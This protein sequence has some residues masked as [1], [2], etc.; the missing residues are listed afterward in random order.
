[1][2]SDAPL[3]QRCREQA[4]ADAARRFTLPAMVTAYEHLYTEL[5]AGR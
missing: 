5:L 4:V 3:A 2:L 1:M